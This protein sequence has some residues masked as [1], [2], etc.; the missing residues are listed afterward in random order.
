[1]SAG[2]FFGT[3]F[4]CAMSSVVWM[5]LGFAIDKLGVIFNRTMTVLP[6]MQDAANGFTMLQTIWLI[7]L[8][9]IWILCWLNYS[10]NESN[11]AGGWV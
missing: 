4:V 10:L 3:I 1:M 7:L 8:A 6:T 9:V 11:E 2:N 5:V